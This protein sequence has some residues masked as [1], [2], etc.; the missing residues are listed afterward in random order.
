MLLVSRYRDPLA[1]H[2]D[3]VVPDASL[4]ED[5]VDKARFQEL[6]ERLGLPV[7]RSRRFS[8]ETDRAKG[9]EVD[10]PLIIK[11]L[12]RWDSDWRPRM[13]GAKA[14][15]A[16]TPAALEELRPSLVG[17]GPLLAQELVEGP[18]SRIESYHVYVDAQGEVVAD[19]S[20]RKIRT[21]PALFGDTTALTITDHE[22]VISLGRDLVRHL[23]LKGVAKFDFKRGPDGR[24]HLLEVNPR[25]NLWHHAGAVAGANLPA[26]VYDDLV[27][28]PR[29]AATG[30]RAGV[31]WCN[32]GSDRKAAKA[33]RIPFVR[34]VLW[35]ATC[36]AKWA[37]AWDD[38]LPLLRGIVWGRLRRG[39]PVSRTT[40]ET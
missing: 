24:L 5:L 11:P 38:P 35:A 32:L 40:S 3:F 13:R 19:F 27:A 16:P 22:D 2:F 10:F 30:V 31:R 4:V 15:A 29:R 14:L 37:V 18:E 21:Y 1:D 33:A 36:R 34:W 25:F 39:L 26:M 20:G 12:T 23:Q 28:R 9:L 6:A 7:P 8:P 17:L